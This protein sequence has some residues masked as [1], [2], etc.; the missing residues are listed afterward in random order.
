MANTWKL[1]DR[2]K[3]Y[4]SKFV[5]VYEDKVEL[6]NGKVLDD[7]TVIEKPSIVMVVATDENNNV[8]ILNEYKYAAG[9]TL[10]SLPAGHK[11]ENEEPGAAAKRELLEET[12]FSTD[13]IE[14]IGILHDYPTKDLHKVFVVRAKNIRKTNETNHEETEIIKYKL[15]SLDE[16]KQQIL[17]KEWKAS[18]ALAAITISGILL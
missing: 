7:Y 1:I 15:V 10:L 8:I 12:G 6:P 4:D 13:E 16:L 14:E 11:K 9:D 3:V 5:K 2:K 18:S 17:N